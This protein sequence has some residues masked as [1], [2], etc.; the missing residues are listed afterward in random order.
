MLSHDNMTWFWEIKNRLEYEQS[1]IPQEKEGGNQ[2][3]SNL[4]DEVRQ[5]SFLPLSHVTAQMVDFSRLICN[6]RTILVTFAPPTALQ[7]SLV[8]TFKEVRP[9]ELMAV[10]RV[11]EKLEESVK[12]SFNLS[13]PMTKAFL[14]WARQRGLDNTDAQMNGE[15]SPFGFNLA[16]VVILDKIKK[17]LGLDRVDKLYYGAA[18]MKKDTSEY[19]ASLNM[20]I[21]S[22]YGLSET[23]GAATYQE[24]PNIK[25]AQNGPPLPGV[26]I[27]IFNPDDKGTGEICIKGRNV[28]M[29]YL[30][31]E[32]LN[33][34]SFD[35]EGYFHTG[36]E[37]Y[38]DEEGCLQITGRIKDIIITAGG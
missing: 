10:P 22:I 6:N 16:R 13:T 30:K 19:F 36:D 23:T 33:Q 31:R 32:L 24:F 26:H 11:Y 38:L 15:R 28:F 12:S 17:N 8:D 2:V 5:V 4:Q 35:G 1:L 7:Q 9:T 3:N 34:E 21:T 37:G 25:F 20:P 27:K 29:G 18:P 14:N